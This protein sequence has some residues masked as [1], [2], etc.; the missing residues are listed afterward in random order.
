[1][2]ANIVTN[3]SSHIWYWNMLHILAKTSVKH[4]HFISFLI[5]KNKYPNKTNIKQTVGN[6]KTNIMLVSK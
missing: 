1:M 3:E 2:W 4:T 6:H 5:I